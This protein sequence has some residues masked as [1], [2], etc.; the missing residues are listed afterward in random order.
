VQEEFL[1]MRFLYLLIGAACTLIGGWLLH[2]MCIRLEDAGYL[3]YRRRPT[4]GGGGGGVFQEL[5]RL[6]RPSIQ[7]VVE[8]HDERPLATDESGSGSPGNDSS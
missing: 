8:V 1:A 4:G 5:D 2:R 7:H 3:Y 6:T